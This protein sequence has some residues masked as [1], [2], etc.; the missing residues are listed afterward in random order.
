MPQRLAISS[1]LEDLRTELARSFV[2]RSSEPK[3][4]ADPGGMARALAQVQ[5]EHEGAGIPADPRSI[6]SAISAF[7]RTGVIV[8]ARDLKYV[9][10]GLG[11]PDERDWCVLSD[12]KMRKQVLELVERQPEMRRRIRSFQALLS[13]YWTFPLNEHQPKVEAMEGWR[14]LRSWLRTEL[15]R[16]V[17]SEESK[18]QWFGALTRYV[19]LLSEHPC[20]KLGAAILRGDASP[21]N[22][23]IDSL[24]IPQESWVMDEA[25]FAQM[26]A[27]TALADETFKK[28]L[29]ELLPI[30]MGKGGVETGKRLQVRCV[31]QF[32]S[33]YA[34]CKNRP[35][36]VAMRDA[37]ISAI[38]NPWLRRANWDA[39]VVDQN[40][41]PDDQAREMV[42]GW[43]KR[44]LI[45]DFFELLSVDG[46]G[47]PRRLEY[48]L[49][50]EPFI[51]DMWFALGNE[52]QHRKGTDFDDFKIRAMGRLLNLE[53]STSDNNA[54]VMRIGEYLA[55]EFGATGNAFYLFKWDSLDESLV[56]MLTAG[57]PRAYV[58]LLNLKAKN[59]EARLVHRDSTEETWEQKFDERI[60][61]LLGRPKEPPRRSQ[62]A[63]VRHGTVRVGSARNPTPTEWSA[64]VR[65]Y[66]LEVVDNRSLKG[67]LWV[68]ALDLHPVIAKQL[69]KW[70]FRRKAVRGW[71]KE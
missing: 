70:G 17:S 45:S 63:R 15:E 35:E 60:C 28:A 43:L 67:A 71:Y 42:S 6:M 36:Q 25:V 38:G 4:W 51:D 3:G 39:W 48:W 32:V 41:K 65:G 56:K 12:P 44:R 47:D 46:T 50:F 52:A 31:A 34:R 37:A 16:I 2:G 58:S 18:P 69:E 1:E 33:R 68:E 27:A 9:C 13:S 5:R 53:N 55:V 8:G 20:E 40:K 24:A 64:F 49:R 29:P 19:E 59:S 57:H 30:V 23:A 62:S 10:L 66:R 11:Q 26:K 14:E 21:L 61:P 7:R 22:D 54:F